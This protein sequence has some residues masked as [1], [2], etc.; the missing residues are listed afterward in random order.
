MHGKLGLPW[1]VG[2]G[3]LIGFCTYCRVKDVSLLSRSLSL[4]L[5][6]SLS[7][8]LLVYFTVVSVDA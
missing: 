5:C 7:L 2:E 3:M 1:D 6:L 8:F 4:S